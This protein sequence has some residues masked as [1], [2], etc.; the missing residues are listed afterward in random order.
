MIKTASD[1]EIFQKQSNKQLYVVKNPEQYA[2]L[3]ILLS[4]NDLLMPIYKICILKNKKQFGNMFA[5]IKPRLPDF[6][7]FKGLFFDLLSKLKNQSLFM[8][9]RGK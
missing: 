9:Y 5:S 3:N 2:W 7:C 4:D 1:F 8:F 6:E